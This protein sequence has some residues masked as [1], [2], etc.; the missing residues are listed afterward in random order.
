MSDILSQEEIDALLD[1]VDSGNVETA[2]DK[3][4]PGTALSLIISAS[5]VAACRRWR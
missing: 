4:P 2:T 5:C 1:G 3:T